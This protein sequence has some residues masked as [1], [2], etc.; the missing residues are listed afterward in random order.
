MTTATITKEPVNWGWKIGTD[1]KATTEN[2][3]ADTFEGVIDYVAYNV[4][5][6]HKLSNDQAPYDI[7]EWLANYYVDDVDETQGQRIKNF[8]NFED[9]INY[10]FSLDSG[11]KVI[12][13][14]RKLSNG[15]MDS[16]VVSYRWN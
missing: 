9:A 12:Y 13:Q 5:A 3:Q 2:R 6:G 14:R 15:S 1:I 16:S 10:Y 7:I 11:H 8:D 4:K